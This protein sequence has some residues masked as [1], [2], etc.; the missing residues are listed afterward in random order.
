MF[1]TLRTFERQ[2]PAPLR[3]N[4]EQFWD[5]M[6]LATESPWYLLT[7]GDVDEQIFSTQ[8]MAV[9][10]ESTLRA[11]LEQLP[12]SS[13][14]AAHTVRMASADSGWQIGRID[15]VWVPAQDEVSRTGGLLFKL[16]GN[17]SLQCSFGK[18]V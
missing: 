18:D 4:R 16:R 3:P 2:L 7:S 14:V 5:A 11:M 1:V 8:T 15:E 13:L 9:A 6:F 12:P 10:W 17:Q